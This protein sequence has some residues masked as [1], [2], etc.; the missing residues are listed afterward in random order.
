DRCGSCG[1]V[2]HT[3]RSSCTIQAGGWLVP[4]S[5]FP[6]PSP[7]S[8]FSISLICVRN[9]ASNRLMQKHRESHIPVS[10]LCLVA[11]VVKVFE[12]WCF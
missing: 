11:C 7:L 5:F 3:D 2:C 10:F 1:S 6:Q 4:V 9:Q 12:I 8:W